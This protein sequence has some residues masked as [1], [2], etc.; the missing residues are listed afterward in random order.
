MKG[1]EGYHVEELPLVGEQPA[2]AGQLLADWEQLARDED[3][4][5]T[6]FD[7]VPVGLWVI[8][9][10]RRL[11]RANRFVG[12]LLR[13]SP[14]DLLGELPG[15]ALDCKHRADVPAGCGSGPACRH[16]RLNNALRGAMDDSRPVFRLHH[17]V[18]RATPA[19]G[20]EEQRHMRISVAPLDSSKTRGLALV[21]LEDVTDV[22]AAEKEL[23]DRR[24][25]SERLRALNE[26]AAAVAHELSQPLQ[27]VL[28]SAD[29]AL[30]LGDD[31]REAL[32]RTIRDNAD[33]IAELVNRMQS[34]TGYSTRSY[35]TGQQIVDIGDAASGRSNR[36]QA[37]P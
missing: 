2:D 34:L 18:R 29:L 11:Q 32:L 33:R 35:G 9:T 12:D 31:E 26:T 37:V 24:V 7:T 1:I 6:V 17:I 14:D 19:G 21:A 22:V 27:A 16:C 10:Q 28:G 4:L 25:E 5:A 15:D 23:S 13:R 30:V 8:D 3:M 20:D 36:Q